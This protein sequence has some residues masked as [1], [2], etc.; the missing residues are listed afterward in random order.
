[1]MVSYTMFNQS[2]VIISKGLLGASAQEIL[3]AVNYNTHIQA[4]R[5][6]KMADVPVRLL[7]VFSDANIPVHATCLIS[8]PSQT[9][10]LTQ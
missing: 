4:Q 2:N 5:E 9:F 10:H 8:V 3:Q 6:V 1:M 7:A